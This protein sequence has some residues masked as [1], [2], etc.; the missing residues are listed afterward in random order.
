MQKECLQQKRLDKS[1]RQPFA[2]FNDQPQHM[3]M[4]LRATAGVLA[5][6]QENKFKRWAIPLLNE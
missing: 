1:S 6:A 5:I 2:L 4:P 3:N